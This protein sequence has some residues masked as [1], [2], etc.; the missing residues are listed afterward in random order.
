VRVFSDDDL[1]A[2]KKLMGEIISVTVEH[3]TTTAEAKDNIPPS[4]RDTWDFKTGAKTL[5]I[6]YS[7]FL[8]QPPDFTGNYP[9]L[10]NSDMGVGFDGGSFGNWYRGNAIRVLVNGSDVMATKPARLAEAK[11]NDNGY[12][13][14]VWELDNGGELALN[15]TVAEGGEAIYSRIDVVPGDLSISDLT[16]SLTCYPGGFGPA[17]KLPSH[18][19]VVTSSGEWDIPQDY[20]GTFPQ[21]PVEKG[22]DWIFYADKLQS[23]G[24][25]GLLF[26]KA[27]VESGKVYMSSYGQSTQLKYPPGTR[28]IH[29]AF[30]AFEMENQTSL[31]SFRS[32]L[33]IER[34]L[35]KGK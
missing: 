18:R 11:G 16:I 21:A 32:S 20:K 26:D 23:R 27:E 6:S 7:R 25:L 34:S 5:T 13:R 17:Y 22:E 1:E 24:S 12:L 4:Q 28:H 29:L 31:Q 10:A 30:Y 35:L 9:S 14:I 15:F 8:N 3:K 19:W 2:L 33:E